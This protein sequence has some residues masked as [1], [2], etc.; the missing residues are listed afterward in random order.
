MEENVEHA[1]FK[2]DRWTRVKEECK[3]EL[4]KS[5]NA[6]NMIGLILKNEQEEC[7]GQ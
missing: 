4:G 1:I 5:V 3:V 7:Y 2:S 6:D